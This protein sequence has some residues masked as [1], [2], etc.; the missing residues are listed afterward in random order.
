MLVARWKSGDR[1]YIEA[2]RLMEA[3]MADD[4]AWFHPRFEPAEDGSGTRDLIFT[5]TTLFIAGEEI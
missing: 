4:V 5:N 1:A 2:R 3:S